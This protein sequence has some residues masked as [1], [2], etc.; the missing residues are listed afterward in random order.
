MHICVYKIIC[1]AVDHACV[2][3]H[4]LNTRRS[5][6]SVVFT[7]SCV[8]VCVHVCVYVLMLVL[9]AEVFSKLSQ[10]TLDVRVLDEEDQACGLLAAAREELR[11]LTLK[12]KVVISNCQAKFTKNLSVCFCVTCVL[13]AGC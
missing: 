13:I 4:M 10:P 1:A 11:G 2:R 7:S 8:C 12:W 5:T 3:I 9:G 6:N